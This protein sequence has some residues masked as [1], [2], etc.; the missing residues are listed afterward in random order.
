MPKRAPRTEGNP[1]GWGFF[2]DPTIGRVVSRQPLDKDTADLRSRI[3]FADRYRNFKDIGDMGDAMQKEMG[4]HAY[5]A[6]LSQKDDP[7]AYGYYSFGKHKINVEPGMAEMEAMPS[8][9]AETLYHELGHM[10]DTIR[11]P[12]FSSSLEPVY[13]SDKDGNPI[14]VNSPSHHY[15]YLNRADMGRDILE[16]GR[17]ERGDEPDH[18]LALQHPWLKK[19]Q[20]YS[21]NPIANPWAGVP[22]KVSPLAFNMETW[23]A[24]PNEYM[25]K[26]I[27]KDPLYATEA[28]TDAHRYRTK[29]PGLFEQTHNAYDRIRQAQPLEPRKSFWEQ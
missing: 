24:N 4:I 1:W 28:K 18:L 12:R 6:T 21:S 23:V 8:L 14:P 9:N 13:G 3:E 27:E 5:D 16:Q 2:V 20:K 26:T 15:D 7:N 22:A 11:H 25:G 19:V 29:R 10:A 17:I